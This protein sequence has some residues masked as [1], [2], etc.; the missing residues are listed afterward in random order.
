ML[1]DKKL[2]EAILKS[3][4]T[5]GVKP[6]SDIPSFIV[7]AKR[8]GGTRAGR[9]FR[10]LGG[11]AAAILGPIEV[12]YGLAL[13]AVEVHCTGWCC[14][15]WWYGIPYNHADGNVIDAWKNYY[16]DL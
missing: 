13:A 11:K 10:M 4:K 1:G 8:A 2:A 14:T 7:A 15:A 5:P 16:F 3:L 12:L 9:A 6:V